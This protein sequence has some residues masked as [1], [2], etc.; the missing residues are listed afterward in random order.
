MRGESRSVPGSAARVPWR[1]E[2]VVA[3]KAPSVFRHEPHGLHD[4]GGDRLGDEVV[5]AHPGPAGLDALTTVSDF[6]VDLVRAVQVCRF[7]RCPKEPAQEQPP[8][9]WIPN[10]SLSRATT[11]LWCRYRRSV[12]L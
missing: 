10:R 4:A 3:E 1:F 9:D 6:A 7:S 2:P 8:R 12:R 5:E 11:K